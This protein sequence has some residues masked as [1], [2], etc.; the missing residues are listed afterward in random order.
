[1]DLAEY[2]DDTAVL[3]MSSS[4]S[5]LVGYIE[6]CLD[7]L[8]HWLWDWRIAINVQKSTVMHF[9]R[10]ARCIHWLKPV[11]FLGGPVQWVE[12]ARYLGVTLDTRLTW[13][14][15]TNQVGREAAHTKQVGRETAQ[16][17][18]VLVLGPPAACLSETVCSFASSSSVL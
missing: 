3:S 9:A 1:M 12:T 10:T 17:L 5:I 18:D 6:A 11:Q 14:A 2:A 15:H 16:R 7:R 13:A 8:E 4:S